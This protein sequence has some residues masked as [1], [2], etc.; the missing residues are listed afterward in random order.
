MSQRIQALTARKAKLINEAQ[1]DVQ[2]IN[3]RLQERLA[4]I[5]TKI[6]VL[7]LGTE[8]VKSNKLAAT[9]AEVDAIAAEDAAAALLAAQM[10]EI[11]N[12]TKI[13]AQRKAMKARGET[14]ALPQ[15]DTPAGMIALL[16]QEEAA[17]L[18][19]KGL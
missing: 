13:L 19:A 7:T 11:A 10:A 2:R 8:F 4:E 6:Q 16:A 17:A 5:D 1:A 15:E 12:A 14:I 18:A 9:E 3:G